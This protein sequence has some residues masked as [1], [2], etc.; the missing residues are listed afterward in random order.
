MQPYKKSVKLF[1][2]CL[3]V[4]SGSGI[5]F[6]LNKHEQF[7]P[8]DVN[9]RT[10]F[11]EE[12]FPDFEFTRIRAKLNYFLFQYFTLFIHFLIIYFTKLTLF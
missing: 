10:L 5:P 1:V 7:T 11:S 2:D 12:I 9:L 3:F 6:L 4:N 8:E